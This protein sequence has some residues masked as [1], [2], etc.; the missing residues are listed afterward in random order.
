MNNNIIMQEYSLSNVFENTN[1]TNFILEITN[2]LYENI[3]EDYVDIEGIFFI[4]DKN[5][6]ATITDELI[7]ISNHKMNVLLDIWRNSGTIKELSSTYG[8][9]KAFIND[10]LYSMYMKTLHD[11]HNIYIKILKKHEQYIKFIDNEINLYSCLKTLPKIENDKIIITHPIDTTLYPTNF[12]CDYET[13]HYLNIKLKLD[14]LI[15]PIIGSCRKFFKEKYGLDNVANE[16][17]NNEF[18]ILYIGSCSFPIKNLGYIKTKYLFNYD[19]YSLLNPIIDIYE[20]YYIY[21]DIRLKKEYFTELLLNI[22]TKQDYVTIF[23]KLIR[24]KF[25][26][27]LNEFINNLVK[28]ITRHTDANLSTIYDEK[29]KYYILTYLCKNLE[30]FKTEIDFYNFCHILRYIFL[31]CLYI[32]IDFIEIILLY[33]DE[34]YKILLNKHDL[35]TAYVV[36]PI[37]VNFYII[38]ATKCDSNKSYDSA[39]TGGNKL[40]YKKLKLYY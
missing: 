18:E 38:E 1:L 24:Q 6:N 17:S 30:I 15:I 2:E 3:K 25:S 37:P 8:K 9:N 11:I 39:I 10:E 13:T 34:N 40:I 19:I 16:T 35:K 28:L 12:F 32:N 5:E 7:Q 22:D 14:D 29:L 21:P 27:N 20:S 26:E 33:S 31:I 23:K 36:N 4:L